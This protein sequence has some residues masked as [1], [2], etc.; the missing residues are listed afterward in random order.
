MTSTSL[1][2][3]EAE[4]LVQ[5]P[6]QLATGLRLVRS[7]YVAAI[8]ALCVL[9]IAIVIGAIF[10][11][12]PISVA[13]TGVI[14]S[15]KGILEITVSSDYEGR[16]T[17]LL[18]DVGD[19]VEPGQEIARIVQP[20]LRT[21]L[22]L[23]ESELELI[24]QEE[25]RVRALQVRITEL[26]DKVSVQQ[27]ESI[28]ASMRPLQ[29]RIKLLDQLAR[30]HET[31]RQNGD[32]TADRY[33]K[34]H[35]DLDEAQERLATKRS[36]L[37]T[38]TLDRNER[39]AQ[40]ERELQGL[41]T[42]RA[43]AQR[44]IDRFRERIRN[45]TVVRSTT[46]GVV[47]EL[48]VFPGDLVRFDTPLISLLPVDESFATLRPGEAHL[49]AALLIPAKD[50]KKIR[51]G[52]NVLIDPTSVRR[53]VFGSIRGKVVSTSNVAASPEQMRHMLRNDDLVRKL[54]A[55]GPPFLI[56]VEMQRDPKAKSGF[57]WT[58][59][60]GP[61][62]Q[63]TAGTLLEAKVLTERVSVLGLLVPAVKELLRGPRREDQEI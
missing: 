55:A 53:D 18:V 51:N 63:I 16:I 36:S 27:E 32:V 29:D 1:F 21:D 48:K 26:L 8:S 7:G 6:E 44:Q 4:N 3:A 17:D 11:Q 62:T 56:R 58:S 40:Y 45:E 42:R 14:L 30:G 19:R 43:Q 23:A 5:R 46:S 41:A 22:K 39:Q 34:V 9:V 38:I 57:R 35:A 28:L 13:G 25:V 60:L 54:T 37:L 15:S 12:V 47:S 31:L 24:N 50:G 33:L 59:S 2:R 52:M 49:V 20:T 10:I 61:D